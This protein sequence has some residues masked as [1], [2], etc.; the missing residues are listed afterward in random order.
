VSD[1]SKFIVEIAEYER[2]WG[3]RTDEVKYFDT[4][5]Q[6]EAFVKK[7]NAGNTEEVAPDWYMVARIVW[8]K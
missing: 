4:R 3:A 8:P 2:G 1:T 7:Y 5:E 6:A